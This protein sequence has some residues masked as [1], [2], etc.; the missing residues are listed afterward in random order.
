MDEV[1]GKVRY[2]ASCDGWVKWGVVCHFCVRMFASGFM[3][4]AGSMAA[5]YL[6]SR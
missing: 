2:C 6:F 1:D 4:A 5:A 3:A